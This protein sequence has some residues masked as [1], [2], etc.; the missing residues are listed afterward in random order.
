MHD[1]K[2]LICCTGT[3]NRL[4]SEFEEGWE[5]IVLLFSNGRTDAFTSKANHVLLQNRRFKV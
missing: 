4:V 5:P 3:N 1:F 2:I